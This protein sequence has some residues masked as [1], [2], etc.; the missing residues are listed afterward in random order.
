MKIKTFLTLTFITLGIF[1]K[2]FFGSFQLIIFLI[3]GINYPDDSKLVSL[4][5]HY[6]KLFFF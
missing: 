2:K 5:V 6:I 3:I 1:F 4:S